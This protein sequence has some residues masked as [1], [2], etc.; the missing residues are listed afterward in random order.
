VN[1]SHHSELDVVVVGNVGIDTN[2]YLPGR[3][4][5][6]SV[7]A[8]YT[9]N[10]DCVGQAGGYAARGYARLGKRTSFIGH[11]GDDYHGR[12]IQSVLAADGIEMTGLFLDPAGTSRS[13]NIMY[14][15]GRRKNF[16]DGKGHMEIGPNLDL[17]RQILGRAKL[18][19]FSLPNWA[20]HLLPLARE[21]G[22]V[23][24]CDIQDVVTADDPYRREFIEY[25]DFL[26]LSGANQPD[27]AP[28]IELYLASNPEQVIVVGMGSKGCALGTARGIEYFGPVSM[29]EPVIDT[30]GAGDSLAVGFLTGR[31]LE[32]RPLSEAICWGQIAARY[33][34]TLKADSSHLINRARLDELIDRLDDMSSCEN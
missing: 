22:L 1:P 15:D 21:Q 5:D 30:N 26:F 3:D 10:L 31:V 16:Y 18:A 32:G 33:C 19:H 2:V 14:R 17:C 12:F 29:D 28:L 27:P 24:A 25:A 11:V 6:F 4:I 9:E 8:N 13:V 7:E 23:I 34:C 20:R